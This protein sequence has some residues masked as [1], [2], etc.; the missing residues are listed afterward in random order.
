MKRSTSYALLAIVA[1]VG[2]GALGSIG[3]WNQSFSVIQMR[4]RLEKRFGVK[5]LRTPIQSDEEGLLVGLSLELAAK[6]VLTPAQ[7]RDL[8]H[9]AFREI[10]RGQESSSGAP[11]ETSLRD[12]WV[13]LGGRKTRYSFTDFRA[14]EAVEP[15]LSTLFTAL[16]GSY[17][18]AAKFG[19]GAV[20]DGRVELLG[21]LR[22]RSKAE[23]QGRRTRSLVTSLRAICPQLGRVELVLRDSAGVELRREL[24]EQGGG[25]RV[26]GPAPSSGAESV[27]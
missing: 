12:I 4:P 5:I 22:V 11:Q 2:V 21:E 17:F 8:A 3:L 27:R 1:L 23:L 6:P 9:E 25:M 24:H 13:N 14:R 20:S 26:Q 7:C 19:L 18:Q 15:K 10:L 16:A